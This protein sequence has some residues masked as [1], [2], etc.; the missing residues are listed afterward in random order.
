MTKEKLY[1]EEDEDLLDG[2]SSI[3]PLSTGL[4]LEE[5]KRKIQEI[6]I[7]A[8][9]R[10]RKQFAEYDKTTNKLSIILGVF[11]LLQMVIALLQLLL[12]SAET[13][14]KI[15]SIIVAIILPL[16]VFVITRGADKIIKK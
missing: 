9:L 10:S 5:Q 14:N 8:Q 12:Q 15:M 2:M 11:A 6:Q 16:S 7:K 13:K 4:A 1:L 3:G